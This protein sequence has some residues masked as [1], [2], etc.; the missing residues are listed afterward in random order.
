MQRI[1]YRPIMAYPVDGLTQGALFVM[2]LASADVKA[3]DTS[4]PCYFAA[5]A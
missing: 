4:V 5:G 1:G 3:E 2:S